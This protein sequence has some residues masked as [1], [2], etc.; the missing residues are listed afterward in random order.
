M[1]L[2]AVSTRQRA[3]SETEFIDAA[4]CNSDGI[5]IAWR[6]KKA[7]RFIKTLNVNDAWNIYSQRKGITL[8][9]FRMATMG[10]VSARNCHPF[11]IPDERHSNPRYGRKYRGRVTGRVNA[12]VAHNGIISRATTLAD[13]MK[14]SIEVDSEILAHFVAQFPQWLLETTFS[15]ERIAIWDRK[16]QG[17]ILF[18]HFI[19]RDGL[20]LSNENHLWGGYSRF[21][22]Y[23]TTTPKHNGTWQKE[24]YTDYYDPNE[25][26]E[27][28][29]QRMAT[30][31][32]AKSTAANPGFTK[33]DNWHAAD[34]TLRSIMCEHRHRLGCGPWCGCEP[35]TNLQASC[36][37]DSPRLLPSQ[38]DDESCDTV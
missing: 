14:V 28:Y 38:K 24:G 30:K 31:S 1:C 11:V 37:S 10:A 2:L 34:G 35:C 8:V 5:G 29:C 6:E 16:S 25:D 18:G 22:D 20:Y 26:W 17:P 27:E 23:V 3:M 19:Q 15:S 21:T 9:H 36:A 32:A 4:F 12:I 7:I 13:N 33:N